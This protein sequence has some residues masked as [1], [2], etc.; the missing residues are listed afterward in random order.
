MTSQ[1]RKNKQKK[2]AP[3]NKK[4]KVVLA[5]FIELYHNY[6]IKDILYF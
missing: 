4:I 2:S 6:L 1:K 3:K 5:G